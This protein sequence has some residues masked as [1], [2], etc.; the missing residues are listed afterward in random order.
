MKRPFRL[1]LFLL[2][3]ICLLAGS[4]LADFGPKAQLTVRV[5]NAPAEPYYLDILAEGEYEGHTY[6]SGD[7][8]YSGLDWSYSPEEIAALDEAL[9]DA[10][11]SAVPE[12]WLACTAEGTGGVPMWGQLYAESTDAAGNPLHVFGYHGLPETYRI[13]MVTQSGEVFLSDVCTRRVLQSSV[14][15]DWAAKAADVPPAW[16]AWLLQFLSMLLPTLVIEGL[17]LMLFGYSW[18]R[19]WKPFLLVNLATQGCFAAYI[20]SVVMGHGVS[21]WSMFFFIPAEVVITLAEVLLYRRFLTERSR[22]RAAFYAVFANACSA[23][24]GLIAVGPV[25]RHLV[26]IL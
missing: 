8:P 22:G 17:L 19:S 14:T 12:G 25:W 7:T 16:T 2:L 3:S 11:R 4:A 6:G 13:L 10:L 9:L 5:E 18:K 15:V 20:A 24:L 26:S 21:G 23:A 1:V